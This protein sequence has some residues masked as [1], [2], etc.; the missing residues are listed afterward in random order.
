[1]GRENGV[2]V[3]KWL[4]IMTK[5]RPTARKP[6][7][8]R[9]R[10]SPSIPF[11]DKR[12]RAPPQRYVY[13]EEEEDE[14]ARRVPPPM[15][16]GSAT[17]K[18]VKSEEEE[19]E[20]EGEGGAPPPKKSPPSKRTRDD[21]SKESDGSEEEEQE[22]EEARPSK[23]SK[24]DGFGRPLTKVQLKAAA[25]AAKA[26]ARLAKEAETLQRLKDK[27]EKAAQKAAAKTAAEQE[28]AEK[29]AA[30]PKRFWQPAEFK[31]TFL[32]RRA[33]LHHAPMITRALS[34]L[35]HP[36]I[37]QPSSHPPE[38]VL[39]VR[40]ILPIYGPTTKTS[41]T[42]KGTWEDVVVHMNRK[43]NT[44]GSSLAIT[45]A[46]AYSQFLKILAKTE[47]TG[48]LESHGAQ[49]QQMKHAKDSEG[50][51]AKKRGANSVD[52]AKKGMQSA[53]VRKYGLAAGATE[54]AGT[55]L[56]ADGPPNAGKG[57]ED[58]HNRSVS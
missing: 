28:K 4:P 12:Q 36:P 25:R 29:A 38:L 40:K 42:T 58:L 17:K 33:P 5:G 35:T 37:L 23:K 30:K 6:S 44:T 26:T 52:S 11:R 24:S 34:V 1:M 9:K 31:R 3:N 7:P 32:V 53:M 47:P 21:A 43:L 41:P 18:H 2:K 46:Q 55:R 27:A 50:L 16:K 13:A 20:E 51:I 57:R 19:E 8:S 10:G 48:R 22:E 54:A 45:E 15:K 14:E 39:S 56:S 49:E